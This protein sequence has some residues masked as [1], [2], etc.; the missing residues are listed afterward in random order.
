MSKSRRQFLTVT[1]VGLVGAAVSRTL[2]GQDV[3]P[4]QQTTPGAP[5]AFGTGPLVGPEISPTTVSEAEKLVQIEMS[6]PHID[7]AASSWRPNMAALYERRTGP[8]KVEIE[9]TLA[10]A[11]TWNPVIPGVKIVAVQDRFVRSAADPGPL[12]TNDE[13]IAFSPVTKL[14]RWIEQKKLTS[15]RLTQIYLK[16]IQQYDPKLRCVITLTAD[17]AMRQ[18]KQADAEIAAGK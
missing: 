17:H 13:D 16:R 11:T 1:S 5:T 14:S 2:K 9:S 8:R 6:K 7:M 15:T 3:P 18:A 10:P 12:P 4:Q